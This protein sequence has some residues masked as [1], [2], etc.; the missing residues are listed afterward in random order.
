MA[1]R[2]RPS[3]GECFGKIFSKAKA[4]GEDTKLRY[5]IQ[6]QDATGTS[7]V[8]TE[9]TRAGNTNEGTGIQASNTVERA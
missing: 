5:R 3:Y 9:K 7:M 6:N 4:Y 1:Q 2:K 8:Q